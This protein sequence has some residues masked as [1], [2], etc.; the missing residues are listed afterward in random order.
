MDVGDMEDV[1]GAFAEGRDL[2]APDPH[3]GVGQ[4][5]SDAREQPRPVGRD[6]LHHGMVIGCVAREVDLRRNREVLELALCE[7]AHGSRHVG[8]PAQPAAQGVSN[9]LV[10]GTALARCDEVLD[11]PGI[12]CHPVVP[13][14]DPGIEHRE[15]QPPQH[16]GARREQELPVRRVDEDLGASAPVADQDERDVGG[17]RVE[18]VRGVPADLVRGVA[19]EVV[20]SEVVPQRRGPPGIDSGLLHQR[21]GLLPGFPRKLGPLDRVVESTDQRAHRRSIQ[22]VQ[23]GVLPVVPQPG[24]RAADVRDGEQVEV[25]EVDVV[26]DG[27]GELRHH[28]GVADVAPLRGDRHQQVIADQPCDERR[29]VL[30][31]A[32][33]GAELADQVGAELGVVRV[34]ALGDV[35]EESRDV[36]ELG[37]GQTR[38]DVR[39]MGELVVT[40]GVG[41]HPEIADHEQAVLVD[42]V[43]VEQVVL[44][45]TGHLVEDGQVG[46]ENPVAMHPAQL[47]VD[48]PGLAQ[49][50]QKQAAGPDVGPEPVVD[51]M[52]VRADQTDGRCPHAFEIGV[53]L[54]QQEHLQ[55]G[56]RIAAEDVLADGLHVAVDGLEPPVERLDAVAAAHVEDRFLEVLEQHLVEP[57]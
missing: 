8:R 27:V 2:R 55:Q 42:G 40:G 35:V 31:E 39:A 36:D 4:G 13:G 15:P 6:D 20:V 38:E 29:V 46:A 43:D 54:Q 25:V 37:L 56:E 24:V 9:L 10:A 30:A 49:D 57:R 41:E 32:V 19:Q 51:A 16:G 7:P 14:D 23:Q 17:T 5:P 44:H 18:D 53:L 11:H 26:A 47:V 33:H 1:F 28:R 22:I 50:L 52:P 34:A 21:V 12:E 45:L 48:A 3:A